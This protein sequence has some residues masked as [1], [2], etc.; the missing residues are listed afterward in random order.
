MP[1]PAPPHAD[2]PMPEIAPGHPPEEVERDHRLAW[3]VM[4]VAAVMS[5]ASLYLAFT[6][7]RIDTDPL[8]LLSSSLPVRQAQAAYESRFPATAAPLVL[9]VEADAPERADAAADALAD[10]LADAEAVEAVDRPGGGDYFAKQGL[11]FREPAEL[12]RLADRLTSSLPL[13]ASLRSDP[14]VVTLADRLERVLGFLGGEPP[15][16]LR[17][18][19]HRLAQ[20]FEDHAGDAPGSLSWRRFLTS[21][22]GEPGGAIPG[23]VSRAVV[24]VA[25]VLDYGRFDAA[26]GAVASVRR[27]IDEIE[28]RPAYRGVEVRVTGSAALAAEEKRTLLV[29]M[30]I[31]GPL[32]LVLVSLVLLLALRAAPVLLGTVT[33]LVVGLILTAG[34]AALAVG[35]LNLISIAFAVLYVGLGADFAIHFALRYRT[36]LR[37]CGNCHDAITRTERRTWG[38]LAM[39][40]VTT[41]MGFVAFVP[42]AY[43]GVS[44]LGV[45]AGGGMLISLAVTMTVIPAVL[46][47][48]P[49]PRRPPK[50]RPVPRPM[51]AVLRLPVKH[52][53]WV[54]GAAGAAAVAAGVLLPQLRFNPDPLD[55]R[56]PGSEAV[57]ALRDLAGDRTL[58]RYAITAM[59]EGPE[60]AH[61]LKAELQRRGDL[62]QRVV[63]LE[64][65]VPGDQ[66]V[67]LAVIRRLRL[68]VRAATGGGPLGDVGEPRAYTVEARLAALRS[69]RDAL[70][71]VPGEAAGR[72]GGAVSAVIDR[73]EAMRG[74]D[75][76]AYLDRLRDRLLGTLPLAL[77]RLDRALEAEAVTLETL[78]G[79]LRSQW[80]SG[81]A[82]SGG[83][84]W[85]VEALPAER[86][87]SVS[88]MRPAVD[89]VREAAGA[90]SVTG[91]PVL[92]IASGDAVVSAFRMALA[93]AVVGIAVVLLLR[94]RSVG[95][96]ALVL[97]PLL[98]G[99]ALTGAFMVVAG[100]PLNFANVIALPLLLGVG[101][102]NG[103]HMVHRREHGMPSHG[104]LLETTTAR[105]VLF[106]ALTTLCSFG[107]L[108]ISPH[109]GMA[110]MGV[111]L[112]V[113]VVLMLGCTLILLPA[114][115]GGGGARGPARE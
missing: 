36:E 5:A 8:D 58:G 102:D 13:V 45:I 18:A 63:T 32:S 84:T 55:L 2:E 73:T 28:S 44:E 9:V 35:R 15:A 98:L 97:V 96:T 94:L 78:P 79:E 112:T 86:F 41:A 26:G 93:L 10:A 67:K 99:G 4:A 51:V 48:M 75:A 95:L 111:V 92:Q 1:D 3:L 21:L 77:S 37:K 40:A 70:A 29:S 71:G 11:L 114:F 107:N 74:E 83:A 113:G 39:C 57:R 65:F 62:F 17:G 110:S 106:S 34:F 25:P 90:R 43:R 38:T 47:L 23:G 85:R 68:A 7:L 24:T 100:M 105:A 54:L 61:A 42:T 64:S 52:R 50:V 108:A 109:P 30:E 88:A 53:G 80:V 69:L 20:A 59:A 66:P 49:K 60:A 46:T 12:E 33:A 27:V 76:A 82:P 89:A 101:V 91:G 56:D 16:A 115:F 14:S 104:N 81:A 6:G 103:I 72:L 19:M 22:E 87:E 31:I